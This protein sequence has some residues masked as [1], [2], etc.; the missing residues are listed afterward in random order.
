MMQRKRRNQLYVKVRRTIFIVV[1]VLVVFASL[2]FYQYNMTLLTNRAEQADQQ[3]LM[4]HRAAS[5]AMHHLAYNIAQQVFNDPQ[6]AYLLY[7]TNFDPV[8]LLRAIAQLNNYRICLPYIQSIYVYNGRLRSMSVSSPQDGGYDI[9]VWPEDDGAPLFFDQDVVRI[10][11]G[12]LRGILRYVAIP[13]LIP[14]TQ[15][16]APELCYTF[17]AGSAFGREPMQEGV[18]V[19]FSTEWM[20]Q[21]TQEGPES[22]SHTL[23]VNNEGR[24]I[25]SAAAGEN[26]MDISQEPMFQTILSDTKEARSFLADFGGERQLVSVLP[27]DVNQ[28]HYFRLTPYSRVT[29]SMT[30]TLARMLLLDAGLILLGLAATW[31][32]A[33]QLYVPISAISNRLDHA[34]REWGVLSG[35]QSLRARLMGPDWQD[36]EPPAEPGREESGYVLM[37][38]LEDRDRRIAHMDAQDRSR[39][40]RQMTDAARAAF[41]GGYN[42]RTLLMDEGI[43]VA[44]VL[45]GP[46]EREA[47]SWQN[48]FDKFRVRLN[49]Q[50]GMEI[51]GALSVRV[52]GPGWMAH[53]FRQ[54]REAMRYRILP[55]QPAL[56]FWEQVQSVPSTDYAYPQ[57]QEN[58]MIDQI[59]SGSSAAAQE[60]LQKIVERSLSCS[61][62][63]V[64]LTVSTLTIALMNVTEEMRRGSFVTSP[65]EVKE[66][67]LSVPSLDEVESIDE[68]I[69]H[70]LRIID[71]LCASLDDRRSAKHTDLLEYINKVI[72][73]TY[74]NPDCSL[75]SIAQ[76]TNLSPAYVGRLYKHYT[77]RTIPEAILNVRMEQACRLLTENRDSTIEQIARQTGFSGGSYF[78]KIFRKE[79]GISPN[80][81]RSAMLRSAGAEG[82]EKEE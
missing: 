22:E 74:Q 61:L 48:L 59:M 38:R 2:S 43:S 29:R 34:E 5:E 42:A 70:F 25:F 73:D 21:I 7:N 56:I 54:S 64:Q 23:V 63:T 15:G 71:R 17:A 52:Q 76:Q 37:L 31:V 30:S 78:S 26:M 53:A 3:I 9:P 47:A 40:M 4:T 8:E 18:F 66:S 10:I 58:L 14:S 72:R 16:G 33:K 46:T 24:I 67:L 20:K 41:D 80:E 79:H 50:L 62:T 77:L 55:Q 44:L 60:S 28:W 13:R 49:A 36:E 39:L 75:S 11:T 57:E 19:N 68:I 82:A 12:D 69:R 51:R 6:I 32:S 65:Q 81:Y 27:A 35:Q 1:A 45:E